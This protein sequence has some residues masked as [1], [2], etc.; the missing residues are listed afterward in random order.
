VLDDAEAISGF[1]SSGPNIL[2]GNIELSAVDNWR[3]LCIY[4]LVVQG[5]LPPLD[6]GHEANSLRHVS[7]DLHIPIKHRL[8][9]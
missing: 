7:G 3:G 6:S 8:I 1:Q 5:Y 4:G 9:Y 2:L